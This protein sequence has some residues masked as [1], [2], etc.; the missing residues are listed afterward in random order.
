[1]PKTLYRVRRPKTFDEVLGQNIIVRT[2]KNQVTSNNISHAYL[3]SGDRGTGKTSTA[4]ILSRAINCEN[5]I[6]GNPCNECK[7]CRAILS[8]ETMDILEMDAASKRTIQDIRDLKEMSVYPPSHGKYK[9]YIVDEVHMLTSEAFNALLKTLE[10]PAD[11]LIFILATTEPEKL[12]DTIL[13]RCQR[14]D[15]ARVSEKVLS[16]NILN[17]LK[18]EKKE[19]EPQA[20][21]M[22]VRE[23]GGSV[24]DSL[25]ILERFLTFCPDV[26]TEENAAEIFGSLSDEALFKIAKAVLLS[27]PEA[28][29]GIEAADNAG[30]DILVL[31]KDLMRSFRAVLIVKLLGEG[32]RPILSLTDS[33]FNSIVEITKRV[34]KSKIEE[35]LSLMIDKEALIKRSSVPRILLET[36]LVSVMSFEE[37]IDFHKAP[38]VSAPFGEEKISNE[39]RRFF[40]KPAVEDEEYEPEPLYYE[41]TEVF[42]GVPEDVKT[43]E[44]QTPERFEEKTDESLEIEKNVE[45]SPEEKEIIEA[46]QKVIA[47]TMPPTKTVLGEMKVLKIENNTIFLDKGKIPQLRLKIAA[48]KEKLGSLEKALSKSLG[49]K[50][51]LRLD[52]GVPIS[53]V[54]ETSDDMEEITEYFGKENI[55]VI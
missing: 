29:L 18:D 3:F 50:M 40:L 1:M 21:N 31:Y 36:L 22:I 12:P 37:T 38:P 32:A 55:T 30:K 41:E 35:V 20:L 34:E 4:L 33:I 52:E 6:N 23:A 51:K 48:P 45:K 15:F 27:N 2:L 5:P 49:A 46:W 53:E 13:S 43:E 42:L 16:D 25:S 7:T 47:E 17:I 10:E 11:F 54:S 14:F 44:A 9:C 39:E 26:I 19:I 28:L 8:G 24:R